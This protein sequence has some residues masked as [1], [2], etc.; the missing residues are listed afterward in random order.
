MPIEHFVFAAPTKPAF[1]MG[2]AALNGFIRS[3]GNF[4]YDSPPL[5]DLRPWG[6]SNR[7]VRS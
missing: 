5:A 2:M 4:H 3:S 1:V 7:I 6:T